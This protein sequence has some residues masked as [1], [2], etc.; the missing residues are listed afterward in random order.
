[1]KAITD[2]ARKVILFSIAGV[3]LLIGTL[4][5]WTPLPTGIPLIAL[6]IVILVSVSA[7]A[8]RLMRRA[9]ERSS[10]LD[11]GLA[12]VETRAHRNMSTMLRRTRPLARKLEAK[13]ALEAANKAL[14]SARSHA[15]RRRHPEGS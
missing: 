14:H 2:R 5:V 12:F 9:R 11:R 15:K 6:G 3:C 4:T 13:K 7:T 10:R 1:M 8:R